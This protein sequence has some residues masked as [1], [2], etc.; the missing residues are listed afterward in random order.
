MLHVRVLATLILALAAAAAANAAPRQF[1]SVPAQGPLAAGRQ[2]II[3]SLKTTTIGSTVDASNGDQNP[4]G[5]AI[6]P[7]GD[8][9]IAAGDLVVCNFNDALNIQGLGTTIEVLKPYPGAAPRRLIADPRLTGC[10]AIAMGGAAPWVAALDANDNPIVSPSGKSIDPLNTYPWTGAWGEGFVAGPHSPSAFYESNAN[11]GSIVRI[12]LSSPF[13]FE[14]IA[15]GLPVNHGVP[16]SILAPSG[17]TYDAV[18]D[19]LYIVDGASNSVFEIREPA[20]V[21]TG[22]LTYTPHGF[23][24]PSAPHGRLLYAG[25]PLNGP[26][27]AA[28]LFNGDLVV[29]NTGDNRLVELSPSGRVLGTRLVDGGVAGAIFGIAASGTSAQTTRVY[30]NDDNDNTV[31]RLAH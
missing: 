5:L 13:T 26:I 30:F 28:L 11:D 4:Y 3:E 6:A 22:G 29:G 1:R 16:G 10:A 21:H 12:N 7:A 31:K 2:S 24:G 27:S 14:K 18:R 19:V 23:T 8:G 25:N 15:T 17:L 9:K 20:Q